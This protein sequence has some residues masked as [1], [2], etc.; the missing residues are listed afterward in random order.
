MQTDNSTASGIVNDEVSQ[1]R[2]KA[3]DM[4][5]YWIRD[6]AEQGHFLIYWAK[7]LGNLADYFTKHHPASHHRAMRPVYVH[8]PDHPSVMRGCVDPAVPG[9]HD[10]QGEDDVALS[11]A[12]I[13]EDADADT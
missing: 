11:H 2:S 4:R 10:L 7:G 5:Y 6:R 13:C 8:V 1:K 12:S 3:M 9:T